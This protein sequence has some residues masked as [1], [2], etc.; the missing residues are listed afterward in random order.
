[1]AGY[2]DALDDWIRRPEA[3]IKHLN[4]ALSR[5]SETKGAMRWLIGGP[6]RELSPWARP[7]PSIAERAIRS[8]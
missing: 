1:M 4:D 8:P 2:F 7:M 6:T 3:K 5:W